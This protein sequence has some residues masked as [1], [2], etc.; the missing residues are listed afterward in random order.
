MRDDNLSVYISTYLLRCAYAYAIIMPAVC[1]TFGSGGEI[2]P[3]TRARAP[4][5]HAD[6]VTAAPAAPAAAWNNAESSGCIRF[7]IN[8]WISMEQH[9]Q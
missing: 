9:T 8:Y 6:K 2:I 5:R 3:S 4:P 1:C 7:I